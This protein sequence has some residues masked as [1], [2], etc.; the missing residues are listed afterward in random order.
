MAASPPKKSDLRV[1]YVGGTPEFEPTMAAGV[2]DEVWAASVRERMQSFETFLNDYFTTVAVIHADDYTQQMSDDYDVTVMDGVPQPVLPGYQNREKGIYL[3]EGYLTDDFDRPMLSIGYIS[4]KIGRRIGTKHDWYCL[5]LRSDAHGWRADHPIFN[6]PFAVE[7]TVTDRPTPEPIF[8]FPH[9]YDEG[10]VPEQLPMWR[11]QSYEWDADR[12]QRIGMVAR[13]GG[14]EDSPDAEFISGGVSDKSP[15]A[16][17]IGRHGNFF[18]WGFAAS[19]ANMTEEAKPVLANAIVYISKFAGQTPIARKYNDRIVTRSSAKDLKQFISYEAYQQSL[20]MEAA[21]GEMMAE[22]RKQA[23]EKQARGEE[24]DQREAMALNF[25]PQPPM[26]YEQHIQRTGGK[27]FGMFGTDIDAA[28]KYLDD[29]YDYFVWTGGYDLEV[30]EDARSLGIANYNRLILDEAIKMLETG[31]D[32][33]KGRRI[34]SRFTI[35]DFTTPQQWRKWYD[36][37]KDLLFFTESGGW[38]FLIDSREPGLNDYK[39]WQERR[40][41]SQVATDETS[42]DEPVAVSAEIEVLQ[43]GTRVLNVKISIH[44]GY[45]IYDYVAKSDTFLPTVVDVELPEG[46]MNKG[47]LKRPA[48]SFYSQSGTTVY[49]D[50]VLFSQEFAGTGESVLKCKVTYQCCDNNICFPPETKEFLITIK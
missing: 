32:A 1:L 15:D 17:A 16:V 11:V 47:D 21:F 48:G 39:A 13:P 23:E 24:L 30:D 12:N 43:D 4:D 44:P 50:V 35:V 25:T 19:P 31:H 27:L 40:A 46:Y 42:D 37:Y 18:H 9:H 14:Y 5:C 8:T 41:A 10:R 20:G 2:P 22:S 29:N 7:M 28:R 38:I 26:T 45:H 49:K 34:L 6:G 33:D 3:T 36:T